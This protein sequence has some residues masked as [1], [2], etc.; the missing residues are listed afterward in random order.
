M[1]DMGFVRDVTRIL[2][3][4]PKRKNLGMF[5]ATISRETNS[6]CP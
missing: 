4:M 2:D 1:L 5:S 3:L 6:S